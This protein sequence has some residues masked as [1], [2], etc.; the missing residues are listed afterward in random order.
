MPSNSCKRP[1]ATYAG[2]GRPVL[3]GVG[4]DNH[5]VDNGD[6][7]PGKKRYALGWLGCQECSKRIDI[8]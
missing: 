7:M 5:A 1:A 2:I 8:G 6:E 4:A 3:V